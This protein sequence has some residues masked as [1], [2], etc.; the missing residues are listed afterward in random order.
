LFISKLLLLL[1]QQQQQKLLRV[2][3]YV[4]ELFQGAALSQVLTTNCL[5][6]TWQL[7]HVKARVDPTQ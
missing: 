2:S 1:L 5:I 4:K 3:S 6:S 7:V